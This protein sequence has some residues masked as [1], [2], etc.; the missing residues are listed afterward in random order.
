MTTLNT[1]RDA[2]IFRYSH[3]FTIVAKN[4]LRGLPDSQH[5]RAANH[6]RASSL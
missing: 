3:G 4:R 2:G 1:R 6:F 5:H